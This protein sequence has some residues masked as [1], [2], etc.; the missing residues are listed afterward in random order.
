MK[1]PCLSLSVIILKITRNIFKIEFFEDVLYAHG[2]KF[3]ISK[4]VY[5]EKS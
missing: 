1:F 5:S 3:K 4:M 2:T